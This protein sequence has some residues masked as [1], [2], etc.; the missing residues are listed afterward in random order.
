MRL[1]GDPNKEI[2]FQTMRLHPE[3]V[4]AYHNLGPQ[5]SHDL[6]AE[7]QEN[8]AEVQKALGRAAMYLRTVLYKSEKQEQH[9]RIPFETTVRIELPQWF[10]LAT[11]FV[12]FGMSLLFAAFG[13]FGLCP[14]WFTFLPWIFLT[15]CAQL[16]K[17]FWSYP[18]KGIANVKRVSWYTFPDNEKIFPEAGLGEPLIQEFY[19]HDAELDEKYVAREPY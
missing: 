11:T 4:A 2:Q 14:I 5:V 6:K 9:T 13:L 1:N 15:V 17:R 3:K 12:T 19:Y 8:P 10:I 16:Q 18:V 7:L